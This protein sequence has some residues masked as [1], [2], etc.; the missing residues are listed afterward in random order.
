MAF[1]QILCRRAAILSL[2][3]TIGLAGAWPAKAFD[4]GVARAHVDATIEQILQL[5]HSNKTRAETAKELRMIFEE[6]TA[7]P[8]IARFTAG[9]NW[10][11]MSDDQQAQFTETFSNYVAF[12]YA[13]HFREFKG[14]IEDLRAAI[15]VTGV[16]DAGAKGVL[17]HSQMRP[18][19]QS[20]VSIDWLISDRS[21]KT[22]ISD[23]IVEGISLAITQREIIGAML[24]AR[25]G[26][27]D[28]LI[29][30]MEQQQVNAGL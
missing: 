11:R 6:R 26:D 21:G 16:E 9:R 1:I 4:V 2:L 20:E 25:G 30:D 3:A 12:V 22:A 5:V 14:D 28:K 23:L 8:Q 15:S 13:G 10:L 18:S 27:V 7:L 24:D 17:V 19:Q 29:A